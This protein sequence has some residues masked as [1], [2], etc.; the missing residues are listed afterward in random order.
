M[1]HFCP[2]VGGVVGERSY[3]FFVQFVS[4]AAIYCIFIIIVMAVFFAEQKGVTNAVVQAHWIAILGLAAFFGLFTFSM[5][6]LAFKFLTHNLSNIENLNAKWKVWDLAV[7]MPDPHELAAEVASAPPPK[8][9][10]W[11][12]TVVFQTKPPVSE[13]CQS[14]RS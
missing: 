11:L 14:R 5:A 6:M 7:L 10:L 1:D 8:T 12:R 3:K 13:G 2:W 9:P 4:Y